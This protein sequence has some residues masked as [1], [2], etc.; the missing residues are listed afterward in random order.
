MIDKLLSVIITTYKR[1]IKIIDRAIKS[2][3]NQTYPFIEIILVDD[4]L[5]KE[6][7]SVD[8]KNLC[9][10]EGVVYIKQFGNMGSCAARNLGVA[11][12]CGEYIAFL[13]DDDTWESEKCKKQISYLSKGYGLVFSKGIKIDETFKPPKTKP[14]GNADGFIQTPDFKDLLIKN[15]IGTTSQIM[16]TRQCFFSIGGFDTSFP[17]RQDYDFCLRAS[18]KYRIIGIDEPLFC[19]YIHSGQQLS[20][21]PV[22]TLEG[23]L[24]LYKKYKE[25]YKKNMLAYTNINCK[26]AK[27]YLHNQKYL[28]FIIT[29][30]KNI[31]HSPFKIQ[32]IIKKSTEK[33]II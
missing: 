11:N 9:E 29:I 16:V 23:Y 27:S 17:A 5:N 32:Y 7:I 25:D 15:R 14:Y 13:D 18:K 31:F 8:I 1:D 28:L 10:R 3:R 6:T 21:D 2:V 26:L 19:H 33:K 20:K 30:T 12:S 24:L 4:N 22:I